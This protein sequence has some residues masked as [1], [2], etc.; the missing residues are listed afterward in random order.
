MCGSQRLCLFMGRPGT[1]KQLNSLTS[2]DTFSSLG[3][4][5]VMHQTVVREVPSS[6]PLSWNYSYG[7]F[8][9]SFCCLFV[10]SKHITFCICHEIVQILLQC[11][12]L[13]ITADPSYLFNKRHLHMH[14]CYKQSFKLEIAVTVHL[15]FAVAF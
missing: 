11:V 12:Q 5:A 8:L 7:C 3:D 4:R 1:L 2:I 6:I 13:I 15:E 9:F 10:C 14:N